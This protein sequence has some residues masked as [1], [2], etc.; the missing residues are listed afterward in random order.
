MARTMILLMGHRLLFP[1]VDGPQL[2]EDAFDYLENACQEGQTL[3]EGEFIFNTEKDCIILQLNS[4][5]SPPS[6]ESRIQRALDFIHA[7]YEEDIS[8][9]QIARK[10]CLSPCYFCRLFRREMRM[11]PSQY[12]NSFRVTKAKQLLNET[13]LLITQICFDVGFNGLTHFGRV[14]K[15][16]EGCPPSEYRKAQNGKKSKFVEKKATDVEHFSLPKT[17]IM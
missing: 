10:A 16:I 17:I 6:I 12:L 15:Q 14:F 4:N 13:N 5:H 11:S 8:L 1:V 3:V 2:E 7:H 9:E